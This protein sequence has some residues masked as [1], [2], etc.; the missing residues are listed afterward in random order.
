MKDAVEPI[1]FIAQTISF[2]D[3]FVVITESEGSIMFIPTETIRVM[4]RTVIKTENVVEIPEAWG[5]PIRSGAV[6]EKAKLP[7]EKKKEKK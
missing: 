7:K 3:R 2:L 4:E 5:D 1:T 6:I